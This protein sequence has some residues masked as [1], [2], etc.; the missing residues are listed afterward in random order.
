MYNVLK[1]GCG[2]RHPSSFRMSR[3]EGL[4]N[5]VILI[6]RT[7]GDFTINEHNYTVNPG[8]A[9]ILSPTTSY[10]YGNPNG[11][12]MDDWIH[13]DVDS[14]SIFN[15]HKDMTNIPIPIENIEMFTFLIRQILWE[16]SYGSPD[17]S[18][19]NIDALFTVLVNHLIT[20]YENKNNQN[21]TH[22]LQEQFKLLRLEMQ[23]TFAKNPSIE[24]YA[25]KMGISSP[26]FQHLYT[27]FFG[28]SFRKDLIRMRIDHAK[29]IIR[30][31]DLTLEQIAEV[32]GYKS[33]V[34]FYRQFR[35]ITGRTPGRYRRDR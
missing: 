12:Y 34:H 10:F 7:V 1:G 27:D 8:T 17:F 11:D 14:N 2:A 16:K 33:E 35:Q 20:T 18:M 31:T 4:P 5:Y 15:L 32:C 28:I 23:A 22:H 6:V 26:Y 3:P 24:E 29:Y 9:I 13:F 30:T 21:P 19:Q 25:R